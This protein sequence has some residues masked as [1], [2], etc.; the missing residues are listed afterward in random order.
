MLTK[1]SLKY[2][3]H[4]QIDRPQQ[5]RYL[6]KL[7][8]IFESKKYDYDEPVISTTNI[9]IPDFDQFVASNL[10]VKLKEYKNTTSI[11]WVVKSDYTINCDLYVHTKTKTKIKDSILN[12]LVYIISFTASLSNKN[13]EMIIHVAF[14]PD[15]KLFLK[16]F[17]TNEVNSGVTSYDDDSATVLVYRKEECVKVI[18]HEMIHGLSFSDIDDTEEVINHYNSKYNLDCS[19][20]NLNETYTEIW[21]KIINWYLVTKLNN[22]N[23]KNKYNYFCYLIDSEKTFA[24]IQASKI[25][26]HLKKQ[27]K[28]INLSLNTSV[29]GYY[30]A[31]NELINNIDKFLEI[32]MNDNNIF[33][34]ENDSKFNKLML[35]FTDKE[36]RLIK[37]FNK[38]FNRNFR[39]T[40]IE[41]KL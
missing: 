13:R 30:L 9:D 18:I 22:T 16:K 10:R 8:S 35:S 38:I 25:I 7:F 12:L 11:R 33:Y 40:A 34:L 21:A 27:K 19:K 37:K 41:L 3:K 23:T 14:L 24:S 39:M 1:D 31:I 29:V 26:K 5:S 20:I 4:I 2:L 32:K 15:K 6:K 36:T 17:T 28:K